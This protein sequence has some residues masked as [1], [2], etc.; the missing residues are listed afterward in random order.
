MSDLQKKV[1][2]AGKVALLMGGESAE[3]KISL[4]SGEEVLKGLRNAG[5]DVVPVD[6]GTDIVERLLQIKPTRA[7]NIL[8]GKGGEDGVL[9]GLLESMRIPYTGSG[10]LGSALAMDKV[11]SKLIWQQL[12]LP[13]A[14]FVILNETTEWQAVIERFGKVVVKP[15][16]EGSS[17]GIRI[18]DNPADLAEA[19][20]NATQYDSN[21]MAEAYISG[22]EYSV[23]LLGNSVLPSIELSTSHPFY[24]FEAK[25]IAENTTYICPAGLDPEVQKELDRLSL[26]A[27]RALG[28]SGWGRI[29]VM[30]DA[31]GGFYLVEANTAPGM[32]SHSLVPM[33]ARAANMD[34]ET[35]LLNILF[36]KEMN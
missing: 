30:Q 6:V 5:I 12:G 20:R 11:K 22:N 33:A 19:W 23:T 27:F 36:A 35:L 13:T 14:E 1:Q 24:D 9:Q 3:R 16:N 18:A 25:Y 31:G 10:V 29:D 15:V 26:A 7:F 2:Q 34:F 21:V 28:C 4:M 17:I 8:H 32:T